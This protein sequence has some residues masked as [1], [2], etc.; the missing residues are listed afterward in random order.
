MTTIGRYGDKVRI[1]EGGVFYE[2]AGYSFF[3]RKEDIGKENTERPGF[4]Q[5]ML[6]RDIFHERNHKRAVR[7]NRGGWTGRQARGARYCRGCGKPLASRSKATVLCGPCRA[8][9]VVTDVDVGVD[10]EAA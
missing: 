1:V 3:V 5:A 7:S 4:T 10:G 6:R 8:D 2:V 9:G